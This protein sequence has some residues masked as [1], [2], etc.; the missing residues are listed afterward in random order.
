V[1]YLLRD[2]EKGFKEVDGEPLNLR[3]WALTADG[4]VVWGEW[5]SN[6]GGGLTG[7][8]QLAYGGMKT[9]VGLRTY[10]KSVSQTRRREFETALARD[11]AAHPECCIESVNRVSEGLKAYV[12]ERGVARKDV[13]TL[14]AADDVVKARCYN[15][16][17]SGRLGTISQKNALGA[18]AAW[19]IALDVLGGTD[20]AKILGIQVCFA[21]TLSKTLG[22]SPDQGRVY[23]DAA[24]K[25]A[26]SQG[27]LY[28]WFDPTNASNDGFLR[29][30]QKSAGAVATSTPGLLATPGGG[31]GEEERKRGID[32]WKRVEGSKFVEA[33]DMRNMVFGAG[34]SGT[35]GELLKT[36][37]VFGGI[38]SGEP[39]K[40]YLLA[41]VVYLVGGGHHTCHEIFSVAN[42]LVGCNGPAGNGA[43]ASIAAIVRDAYVPGKYL[44]H[45]PASYITTGHFE[46]LREKYYDIAMLGHLHGTFV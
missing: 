37:R 8:M 21:N 9:K 36:Y 17:G 7:I 20:I 18:G 22:Y 41:I 34:R 35:T 5:K 25:V 33:L 28:K 45:L 40:Q 43:K 24:C 3:P 19:R 14:A 6:G 29:G 4:R 38:D 39:F 1:K 2:D 13:D 31:A 10:D 11:A 15:D 42:L 30:R 26:P 46:A 12:A 44:K 32:E 16:T 23:K 27:Y